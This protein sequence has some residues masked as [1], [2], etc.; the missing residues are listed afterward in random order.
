MASNKETIEEQVKGLEKQSKQAEQ[1]Y[2][3][4]QGAIEALQGL[5]PIVKEKVEEKVEEKK[6][7]KK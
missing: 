4:L 2:F 6:K 3:K 7:A 5:I 1:L